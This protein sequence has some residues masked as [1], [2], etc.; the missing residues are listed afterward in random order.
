MQTPAHSCRISAYSLKPGD[1]QQFS[2]E[3]FDFDTKPGP[4]E[5]STGE[6]ISLRYRTLYRFSLIKPEIRPDLV[7]EDTSVR[8]AAVLEQDDIKIDLANKTDGVIQVD[9][10]KFSYID[11]SKHAHQ[12]VRGN[13]P[14]ADR[15]KPQTSTTLPPGAAL[16]GVLVPPDYMTLTL[17]IPTRN[18]FFPMD[19]DA[20]A[21]DAL[22]RAVVGQSVS[23]YFPL[24]VNGTERNIS[25]SIKVDGV[26]F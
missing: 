10:N 22:L 14:Y 9:W 5:I 12:L 18:P 25:F 3:L 24:E 26:D 2:E 17:G 1:T 21:P 4:R 20:N 11:M 19:L 6:L 7:F 13:V 15:D 16:S 8:I 23:L